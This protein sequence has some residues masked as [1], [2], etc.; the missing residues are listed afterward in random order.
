[1]NSSFTPF[2]NTIRFAIVAC[3]LFLTSALHAQQVAFPGAEGA[4]KFTTGGRGTPSTASTVFEVTNLTDVNSPGSLRYAVSATATYRTIVFRV[5]G[6]IH[7]TSK[8]NIKANTTIAG[9][10]APG[11][12]I[13]VADYPTVI[14]GDN[15]IVRYMRFR[16]GDK[17]QKKTD[18]NGNPIDGSGGDDSFGG[19]DVSNIIID[20]VSVSWSDDEALTIYRGDNI[21]VQWSFITEPLNYS[22]HWESGDTDWEHHGFGG[23][24][25]GK[26]A[27]YHHNLFAHCNSRNPRFAGVSSYSPATVGVENVDLRNNV[28]YNWGINTVY[29]GE[30]GNYNVVNNYYKYGP[31]TNSSVRYRTVNPSY[32]ATIPYGKWYV[33]GNYVD[34]S[35]T[36]TNNNW[37]GAVMQSGVAADTALAK[38]NTAFDLG[39]PV[40]TNTAQDAYEYVLQGSGC[41]LPARDTLDQ[42]IVLDVRNRTGRLIDVQGGYPHGTAYVSTV[43][44][45][46]ALASA[47]APTDTDHDGMPDSWETS[48]SLNPNDASDRNLYA[49]NGYTNL[50]NYL[51]SLTNPPAITSA[52]IL[53][54]GTLNPFAQVTGTP[55]ATQTFLVSGINLTS[56]ISINAPANYQ[57][58]ADNGTTW[59]SNGTPLVL[60]QSGGTVPS[61]TITVRLNASAN[62]TY[63]GNIDNSSTGAFTVSVAAT[64]TTAPAGLS[65]N[66]GSFPNM[67]GGFENQLAASLPTGLASHTSTTKWE[68]TSAMRIDSLGARTGVK[69]MHWNQ[70]S[71]S[72]KYAF[73][74]VL[75]GNTLQSSTQYVVQF[76][77]RLPA[78][79]TANI[80]GTSDL[81]LYGWSTMIGSISGSNSTTSSTFATANSTSPVGQ[82]NLFTTTVTTTADAPGNTYMGMKITYPQSPYFDID[83]YVVYPGSAVDNTAP[84]NVASATA[85]GDVATNSITINWTAPTTGI[86]N[87]G[88]IVV[89]SNS[90]AIPVPNTKG[91]YI[92]GNNIGSDS[93]VYVG[94]G[95]SYTDNSV[96]ANANY[97]YTVFTVDKAYN[98]STGTQVIANI[99]TNPPTISTT[100]SLTSFTQNVGTPT[101]VQNYTLSGND[102]TGNVVVTPPTGYEVSNNGGANWYTAGSPLSLATSGG[103]LSSTTI[104]VRLNASSA[105]AYSGNITNASAGA[106]TMNVAVNGIASSVSTPPAGINVTVAKDGT[107]N[108]TTVQA[109]IDAAPT[110]ST[111]PYIIYI[112]N[113]KYREK[114]TI[115]SNKP[116]IHL[117]GESIA[118]TIISWDDY[119]GKLIPGGA[120]ATYGTS[121]SATLTINSTDCML[122]NLT[123]ENTTGDS[124]QALAIN[125]NADRFVSVN[126]RFLGGQDTVLTNGSTRQYFKSTY[127]DG[128]VDFI[129]GGAQ[130]IFDSCVIYPKTR[131][132]GTTQSYITAVNTSATQTYGYVFRNCIIPS[133]FGITSY[134]LGRPWQNDGVTSP[135][136][137]NRA[138]FINT[139]MG[140]SVIKPEGWSTWNS[141]TNTSQIY[142]GEYRSKKF[143]SSLVDVSQRVPWSYQ[144]TAAEA[145]NYNFA[146][147]FGSWDPCGVNPSV[148]NSGA[149]ELV[150]SN[151]RAKKGTSTTNSVISWNISWPMSGV[152]YQ[153]FRSSDNINFTQINQQVSV[154]DTAINFLYA[155]PIPAP[156]T[157]FYYYLVASKAGLNSHSSDTLQISST[158]T[159]T[160]TGSL[161]PFLQGV[162]TPSATQVYS[163]SGVNL[164]NDIVITPPAPYE[165]SSNGGTTWFTNTTPLT[166]TPVSGTVSATNISVRLNGS[167]AGSYAGD[168]THTSTG[169]T[170]VNQP[171]TGTIQTAPLASP[172]GVLE[173]WTLLLNNSDSAAVRAAGIVPTTPVFNKLYLSNGTTVP[174]FPAYSPTYGQAFGAT[175]NGDGSWGTAAGGPGGTINRTYYEEFTV[176]ADAG[177]SVR[178]DSILATSAFYNTSSGT[179]IAVVTSKSG[180]VSDSASIT[181]GKL[182]GT[183]LIS[184][185]NGAFATPAILNNQNSGTFNYAFA[186]AGA[187]GITLN[188]G[189]TLTVRLY[190]SC[191][192]SSV[193]RYGLLKHV[194]AKGEVTAIAPSLSATGTLNAFTQSLGS[195][196]SVQTYSLTGSNLA[197]NVTVTPP[198]NYEVSADGVTWFTTSSPLVITPVSGSISSTISVR[199]NAAA[200]GSYSG[201]ITNATSGASTVNVAVTGTTVNAPTIVTTGTL[202]TFTQTLGTPSPTQTYTVSGSALTSNITV[203]APANY[204]VSADGGLTWFNNSTPLVLTQTSGTVNTTT[205]SVRLNATA[206]GSYSGSIANSSTG[207][208]T[209]NVSV[210]GNTVNPPSITTTGTLNAFAS[211]AGIPS[212]VQ[213]Y[214]VS[215][216]DLLGNLNI[217]APVN[218]EVSSD[219]GITWHNNS[220]PLVITPVSGTVASTTI[221]VRLNAAG[222]GTYSGNI[223]HSSASAITVNVAVTGTTTA[224]PTITTT[225]TLSNFTQVVGSPSATQTYTVSAVALT[226]NLVI[227]PPVNYQV[228][229]DG[230]TTWYTNAAPLSIT[231]VAG[232]IASTTITVRLN[233]AAT[234]SYS[235]N[236]TNS[237]TGAST[238]SVAVN[239][240]TVPVPVISTTGTLTA[241]SQILGTPSAVQTYTVA[242]SNL[243]GAVTITPPANYQVSSN[244]G[245]TWFSNTTPL[246]LTPVSGT[247]ATTTISVRLNASATGTY[248]GN[249]TQSSPS[250]VT[251]NV[252]VTGTTVPAPVVT[253]TGTLTAFS[254][255]L[256]TPSAT[257]T[258]TVS[259]TNLLAPLTIT[260]PAGYE[261][262]SN[263]GTNWYTNTTP[264]VLTPASGTIA[265]TTITVRLNATS[266]GTYAGNI[267]HATT[268]ATTANVAVTGTA[269]P[270]PGLTVTANLQPFAQVL[271]TP[272]AVQ[273]YTVSGSN[274]TGNVT[275]TAPLRYELSVNGG[276]SW[277]LAP[278]VLTPSSGSINTTVMIRLNSPFA[279]TF[280]G[281][282]VHSTAGSANVT[283]PV[284]G[285]TSVQQM[286]TTY[287]NPVYRILYVSHPVLPDPATLTIYNM[288]GQ[289]IAVYNVQPNTSET[290]INVEHLTHGIYSLHYI[291]GNE[292]HVM[293]FLK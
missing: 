192:S 88:Y 176:T 157:S 80:A 220:S 169:A 129:F 1:M 101:A 24:W 189:E 290:P 187:T 81:K 74:P 99:N 25:G 186:V 206:I 177:H 3:A 185:A 18:S 141:S 190:F 112:K 8:L 155:E 270:P 19:T 272:S 248:S 261:I 200:T 275:I 21:T 33:N 162:G 61:T 282:I 82:W 34:G 179:K 15:V 119:S 71:T 60:T 148:C 271:F 142:Y 235:G 27:S 223:A 53:V 287:P 63:S 256:G 158:P 107:G 291:R 153:L 78:Q 137:F 52:S 183:D 175:A 14:S 254:Q 86:D 147:V 69:L 221:S 102:L 191:G 125:V 144:L 250:A 164:T 258:Y 195:P 146:N 269:V 118:N 293:R 181:A 40:T 117:I 103:V 2:V 47:G 268:G 166:L 171:V 160:V 172:S 251:V 204:E 170:Q 92:Q 207:A 73:T 130:A 264:L 244:G 234:G 140:N 95:T 257:K 150:V 228:S 110:S 55:S 49:A 70:A 161:T 209:I 149:R 168:I 193:G 11:D 91:V 138:V 286:Y 249:I 5:S 151:F 218:Y 284:E 94:S 211:V 136:P 77:Y 87:G 45:W 32:T 57:V 278:V 159:I 280:N 252:P 178:V 114:V 288:A 93:V 266:A 12:G 132:D 239:G 126:C 212:A 277:T 115:P 180:F 145:Q 16:M 229:A 72:S 26:R 163:V 43:N 44:A 246:V 215:A 28:I 152:T 46:P 68:A 22:Y 4:G 116:F 259:G 35:T 273:S 285:T 243:L 139:T 59:F 111:S 196:S 236:I 66:I 156:G 106:T 30:G 58:S 79:L 41:T 39:Y 194:Q 67:D 247:I 128:T 262:S 134:E 167:S 184:T 182:N 89:R 38:V 123:V 260:P 108:F 76:W 84:D 10:T 6:T 276:S 213:T 263:G 105:G 203:T 48:N 83:D 165:V 216:S 17:N 217:T 9:Q 64:G 281:N 113:G 173:W 205:I 109:A 36:N 198:A 267:T 210:N 274:L 201:N 289:K 283:I 208:A 50:E 226:N 51:N 54:N 29:G 90:S 62:G 174:A 98:Y 232:V 214:T 237:S 37:K 265:T 279:G 121:N 20:H 135:A 199:L 97:Y 231:P 96:V 240:T 13:C 7:L 127:I 227:T 242:G 238:A 124:P 188:A 253:I 85:S 23:I 197:G 292:L 133:N 75:T 224:L 245:T 131:Q 202:N 233:A 31:S 42:R 100:G 219:G 255:T 56:D 120:G 225:G 122:K 65:S 104:S 154:N 230:G 222:A 143:D 241:F